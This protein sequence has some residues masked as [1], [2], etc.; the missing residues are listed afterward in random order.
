MRYTSLKFL[1]MLVFWIKQKINKKI[2]ICLLWHLPHQDLNRSAPVCNLKLFSWNSLKNNYKML[3]NVTLINKIIPSVP[4]F[5]LK[6]THNEGSNQHSFDLGT[7]YPLLGP[8]YNW[9]KW[10]AEE[11]KKRMQSS[12]QFDVHTWL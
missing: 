10:L 2:W 3:I 4:I 7:P 1:H 11:S 6:K 9:A 5:Y 8:K 12:L